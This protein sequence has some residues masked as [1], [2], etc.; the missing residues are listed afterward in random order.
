M[1]T[2]R[3]AM[4]VIPGT[5]HTMIVIPESS[6]VTGKPTVESPERDMTPF[7]SVKW[8]RQMVFRP[9][10]FAKP[11][12][13]AW[14][15]IFSFPLSCPSRQMNEVNLTGSHSPLFTLNPILNLDT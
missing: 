13:A 14:L 5:M 3:R 12:L 6:R 2:I 9:V 15:K 8:H 10:R 4:S 7:F 1:F 11:H